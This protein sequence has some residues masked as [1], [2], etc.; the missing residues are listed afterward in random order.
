[1]ALS[2]AV[3]ANRVFALFSMSAVAPPRRLE[4]AVRSE[5]AN[6]VGRLW[7]G[8]KIPE[9]VAVRCIVIIE[10]LDGEGIVRGLV[11]LLRRFRVVLTVGRGLLLGGQQRWRISRPAATFDP[12]ARRGRSHT[13][14]AWPH[15][16]HLTFLPAS[17]SRLLAAAP[18]VKGSMSAAARTA[19]FSFSRRFMSASTISF[20]LTSPGAAPPRV[21]ESGM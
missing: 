2:G 16:G 19:G 18:Q 8:Q 7:R 12:R 4:D 6:L 14:V 20:L 1:M 5:P 13:L 9:F 15:A 17:T 10:L 11:R 3:A 21:E